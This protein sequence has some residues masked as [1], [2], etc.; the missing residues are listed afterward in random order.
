MELPNQ[1]QV[2]KY[3]DKRWGTL[4]RE[5]E[6]R[7]FKKEA[8]HFPPGTRLL[9]EKERAETPANLEKEKAELDRALMALPISMD[10]LRARN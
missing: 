5:A 2:P 9:T 1:G 7:K 6:A 4:K 10:T 8:K 3:I